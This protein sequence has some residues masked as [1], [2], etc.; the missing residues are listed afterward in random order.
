M[1]RNA[2]YF[3]SAQVHTELICCAGLGSRP[4]SQDAA[5]LGNYIARKANVRQSKS[6]D[7]DDKCGGTIVVEG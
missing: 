6:F 5:H 2:G 1:N 3:R 4:V 7:G